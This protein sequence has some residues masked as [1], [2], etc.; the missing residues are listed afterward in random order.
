VDKTGWP[1]QVW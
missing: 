1:H